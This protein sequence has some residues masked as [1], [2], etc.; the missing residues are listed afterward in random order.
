MVLLMCYFVCVLPG[1][2]EAS[3]DVLGLSGLQK[4]TARLIEGLEIQQVGR[5]NTMAEAS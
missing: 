2:Y 4:V 5:A 3:L 1:G